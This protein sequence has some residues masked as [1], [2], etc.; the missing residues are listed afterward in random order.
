MAEE[1]ED[2]SSK[3][4]EPTQKKLDDA[5]EKGE[6]ILSREVNHWFMILAATVFLLLFAGPAALQL[7]AGLRDLIIRPHDFAVGDVA[8]VGALFSDLL[9]LVLLAL[10]LPFLAFLV[11]AIAGALVQSGFLWAPENIVPKLDRVSLIQG[12]SRLFSLKNLLEFL[13]GILKLTIVAVVLL[14]LIWPVLPTLEHTIDLP[15]VTMLGELKIISLRLLGGVLAIMFVIA[16]MDYLL[17]RQLFMMRMRMSRHELKE[18]FKQAEGDPQIKQRI[19]Q[20]RAERARRRMMA[21]V[22]KADVIIT[23]PD[24][25]AVALEYKPPQHSAPI[26]IAM[27]VDL[28]AQKIKEIAREHNIPIVENPPLARALYATADLDQQIP[29]EHFKAVAEIISYVFKLKGRSGKKP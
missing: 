4:E 19:R 16:V 22:P 5:R 23:N 9:R 6:I 17:Q 25:Y 14:A 12:F 10:L 28:L 27:G 26:V 3:T 29:Q 20:I 13:K 15:I 2:Q 7:G 24:H 8:G 18:E 21:D 11:A 1:S